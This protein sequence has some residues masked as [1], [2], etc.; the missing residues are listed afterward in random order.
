MVCWWLVNWWQTFLSKQNVG[1]SRYGYFPNTRKTALIVKEQSFEQA[2]GRFG[3]TGVIISRERHL[4]A[5]ILNRISRL[6]GTVRA[7]FGRWVGERSRNACWVC[8]IG[9]TR[10]ICCIHVRVTAKV[11]VFST[12]HSR[13]P[14]TYE[15]L[16]KAIR[17]K[18]ITALTGHTCWSDLEMEL[19]PL[20]CRLG[21]LSE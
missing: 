4:G 20:P 16:E 21:D 9:T 7:G 6:Q 19:F 15:P 5:V 3:K 8:I 14:H 13:Y 17:E 12:D 11:E 18:L 10:S 1:W 2:K